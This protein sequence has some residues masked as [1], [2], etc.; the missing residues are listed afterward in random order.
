MMDGDLYGFDWLLSLW[1]DFNRDEEFCVVGSAEQTARGIGSLYWR[2]NCHL[3]IGSFE[4]G[5]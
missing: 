4:K 5:K 1:F 2:K 3:M